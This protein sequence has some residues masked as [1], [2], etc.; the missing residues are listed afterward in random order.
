MTL[1]D[2]TDMYSKPRKKQLKLVFEAVDA[3]EIIVDAPGVGQNLLLN[4]WTAFEQFPEEYEGYYTK[5][6]LKIK[7][8]NGTRE[9]NVT[10]NNCAVYTPDM[11]YEDATL[12]YSVDSNHEIYVATNVNKDR[13]YI[14]QKSPT[15]YFRLN[16]LRADAHVSA[17]ELENEN[18]VSESL[19]VEDSLCASDYNLRFGRC[20]AKG[21]NITIAYNGT[22][23]LKN[24]YLNVYLKAN[25]PDYIID[26]N[27]NKMVDSEGNNLISFR[28]DRYDTCNFGRYKVFSDKP[29]NDKS[30]RDL[31][32]YDEMHDINNANVLT[33][34]K[35]LTFPMT[36]KD[37][38]DSF[39]SYVGIE[40]E[41]TTLINDS[42]NVQGHYGEDAILLGQ[43]IIESICEIN[44]VFGHMEQKA[45]GDSIF[46]YISLPS[47][48][49]ITYP[50]Y[51]NNTG[52][53]EDYVT[54]VI[55]GFYYIGEDGVGRYFSTSEFPGN[56]NPYVIQDNPI[57]YGA[58]NVDLALALSNL[59]DKIKT[60]SYR[61]FTI[62]T[63]GNPMM[64][65][66]TSVIINTKNKTINSFVMSRKLSGIQSMKDYI[67][68]YGDKKYTHN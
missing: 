43:V 12:F 13:F 6:R 15:D 47:A 59:L 21:F 22:Q 46:K 41:S 11:S 56:N 66:G 52:T 54:D 37:F 61:P 67:E 10:L 35:G 38:R 49:T 68:A 19:S 31:V 29:R 14:Y 64:P 16:L 18:I 63:F 65:V 33:W 53:Y 55:T 51:V 9:A 23:K 24:R 34:F 42:F 36:V 28:S 3:E 50:F 39:F 60:L 62:N 26:S 7:W 40:Q 2:Y 48:E 4:G 27:N 5:V 45:S 57:I 20:E 58:D 1:Q 44:G 30:I 25:I 8:S 17:L 32:C